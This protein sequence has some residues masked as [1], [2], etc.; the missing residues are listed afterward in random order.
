MEESSLAKSSLTVWPGGG[1]GG[2][3]MGAGR[4]G[5]GVSSVCGWVMWV[6]VCVGH[7][8]NANL[9][10]HLVFSTEWLE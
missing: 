8:P 7:G 1:K 3:E 5:G 2:M 9:S 10:L 4:G 6:W